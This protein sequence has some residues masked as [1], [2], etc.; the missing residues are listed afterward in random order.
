MDSVRYHD[1]FRKFILS[2]HRIHLE[3]VS[4]QLSKSCPSYFEIY[5]KLIREMA[6][7]LITLQLNYPLARPL[8]PS[9]IDQVAPVNLQER[10]SQPN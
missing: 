1:Y 5:R 10:T 7:G 2:I 8:N 9:T 4:S 3:M 6:S